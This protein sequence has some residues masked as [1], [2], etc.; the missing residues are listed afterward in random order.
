MLYLLSFEY[1]LADYVCGLVFRQVCHQ[2]F[3]FP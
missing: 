1:I 3:H 2:A